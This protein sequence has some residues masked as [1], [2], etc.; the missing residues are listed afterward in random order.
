VQAVLHD[1]ADTLVRAMS[2]KYR[3]WRLG[4]L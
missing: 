3:K 1:S 2:V 4:V